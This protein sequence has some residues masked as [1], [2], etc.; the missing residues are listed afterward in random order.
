V[1]MLRCIERSA[2][3]SKEGFPAHISRDA[4]RVARRLSCPLAGGRSVQRLFSMFPN[5]WP[6]TGLLLLRIASGAML[7]R[8]GVTG[9]HSNVI[10]ALGA[11]AGALLIAGL[12]TPVAGVAVVVCQALTV[13]TVPADPRS[14]VLLAAIGA[15]LAML[16]PGS[17]SLDNH[18]FG[19]KRFDIPKS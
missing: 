17:R 1:A 19:R 18:F 15:A 13:I 2:P 9:P 6:G 7:I 10:Q 12:W 3:P 14:S 5:G 8:Q 11:V 16:G 4:S